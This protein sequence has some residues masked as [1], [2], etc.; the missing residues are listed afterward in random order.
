MELIKNRLR[1][2]NRVLI[3]RSKLERVIAK[4]RHGTWSFGTAMPLNPS[5]TSGCGVGLPWECSVCNLHGNRIAIFT[6]KSLF[7]NSCK[8]SF[9]MLETRSPMPP[10]HCGKNETRAVSKPPA[11]AGAGE[12]R[13]IWV[14]VYWS[15]ARPL[16]IK[17]FGQKT[18]AYT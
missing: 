2:A 14:D 12:E 6:R 18:P 10:K 17:Q 8:R 7:L 5:L 13:A 4:E 3:V 1:K 15:W 11:L 16:C 9:M